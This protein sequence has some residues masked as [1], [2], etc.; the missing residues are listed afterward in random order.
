MKNLSY[1]FCSLWLGA[2]VSPIY[3]IGASFDCNKAQTKTEKLICSDG[4][5]GKLDQKLA[6]LYKEAVHIPGIKAEQRAWL[7]QLKKCADIVCI[8]SAYNDRLNELGDQIVSFGRSANA[9]P[10]PAPNQAV[11]ATPK[12]STSQSGKQI[13]DSTAAN[14][15]KATGMGSKTVE[16]I[17]N[18]LEVSVSSVKFIR[19]TGYGEMG[20]YY[21]VDTAKGPLEC[22][23]PVLSDGKNF[24]LEGYQ[25]MCSP[26]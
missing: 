5:L 17:A 4:E 13:L 6:D 12:S 9:P 3:A 18:K 1:V 25:G 16:G 11:A 22:I 15:G 8:K 24:W 2:L 21:K 7:S 19:V 20:C 14:C 23:H 10:T 26:R